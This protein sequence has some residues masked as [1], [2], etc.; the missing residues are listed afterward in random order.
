MPDPP[1]NE[2]EDRKH[3]FGERL[4]H[5]RAH[6]SQREVAAAL[7]MPTTTY[8]SL[9]RQEEIPRG[10]VLRR[11]ADHFTVSTSYFYP[12][13]PAQSSELA[14]AWLGSRRRSL[15]TETKLVATHSEERL[16]ETER[17]ALAERVRRLAK[18][19]NR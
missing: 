10:E 15:D 3:G 19:E 18:T 14:K 8:S 4:R 2:P 7:G 11:L 13:R 6:R 17:S 5:L 12:P 9:E 1:S 16:D